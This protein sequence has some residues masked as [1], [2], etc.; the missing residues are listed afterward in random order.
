MTIRGPA[1]PGGTRLWVLVVA[2]CWLAA[3]APP[4]AAVAPSF[5]C[6]K[7]GSRAEVMICHSQSLSRLDARLA[8]AYREALAA[9]PDSA[10]VR[11]LQTDWLQ[12]VRN[13]CTTEPCLEA[14]YKERL[15]QL[16]P[17]GGWKQFRDQKLGFAFSY[18]AGLKPVPGC[19]MSRDCVALVPGHG[20]A[21]NDYAVALEA[22]AGT[23]DTVATKDA[24]FVRS[25]GGWTAH[26]RSGE[27]PAEH[28]SGT[29][30]S[31][32]ASMVDCGVSTGSGGGTVSG[33]CFWAVL[34]NGQRSVVIDTQG[35]FTS[36]AVLNR[37]IESVR[38]K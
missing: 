38:I 6:S 7:A 17:Q 32:L 37:I 3:S 33:D 2:S 18:P 21:A 30:W 22:F 26:G 23:L 15:E 1:P 13:R 36:R 5:D 24:I 10:S 16:E 4:A 25:P 28:L 14:A 19:H 27:H 35:T 8:R 31:G 11:Q 29:D 20:D 12:N 9:E 34:S